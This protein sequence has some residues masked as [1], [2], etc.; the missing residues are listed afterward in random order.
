MD[1]KESKTVTGGLNGEW[2]KEKDKRQNMEWEKIKLRT[3]ERTY[4]N[5]LYWKL[6]KICTYM[7]EI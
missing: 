6:L 4:R 1:E 7:I 5:L 3:I 2:R